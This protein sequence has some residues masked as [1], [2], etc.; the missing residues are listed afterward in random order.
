M[1][2]YFQK[3]QGA[4]QYQPNCIYQKPIFSLFSSKNLVFPFLS[5]YIKNL[6]SFLPISISVFLPIVKKFSFIETFLLIHKTQINVANRVEK[7]MQSGKS[8]SMLYTAL[9]SVSY[10]I[11]SS[12]YYALLY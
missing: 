8:K 3:I 9:L 7:K 11:S 10:R 1:L 4:Y 6:V 2:N 12:I 5:L